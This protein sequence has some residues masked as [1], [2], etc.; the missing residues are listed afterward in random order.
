[1]YI[2]DI[3]LLSHANII[4]LPHLPLTAVDNY[5]ELVFLLIPFSLVFCLSQSARDQLAYYENGAQAA[6]SFRVS[7]AR[8]IAISSR[9]ISPCGQGVS[10]HR[11]L[12]VSS[13]LC[14]VFVH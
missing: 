14:F 7:R 3:F 11:L 13:F 6:S 1:M 9:K 10:A 8:L 12:L 4:V 2:V 5:C